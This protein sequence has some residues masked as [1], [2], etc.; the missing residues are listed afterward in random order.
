MVDDTSAAAQFLKNV[1]AKKLER[2]RR[3]IK[4]MIVNS[5][6]PEKQEVDFVKNNIDD[7]ME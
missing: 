5:S 3:N 1:A 7:F 2:K 6:N 4:A